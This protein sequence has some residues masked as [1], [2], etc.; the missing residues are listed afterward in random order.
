MQAVQRQR[1]LAQVVQAVL[2]RL[3]VHGGDVARDF[4]QARDLAVGVG[5]DVAVDEVLE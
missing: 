2:D 5:G 1:A 3:T 4:R